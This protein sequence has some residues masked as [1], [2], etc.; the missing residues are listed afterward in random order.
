M[1]MPTELEDELSSVESAED[2]E[3]ILGWDADNMT[4]RVGNSYVKSN[5]DNVT[6]VIL[7]S[8]KHLSEGQK[9]ILDE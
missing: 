8:T 5:L 9:V 6:K 4:L 7:T 2:L 1:V 3:D